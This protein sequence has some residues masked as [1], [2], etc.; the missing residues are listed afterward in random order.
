MTTLL[1]E[2]AAGRI[3]VVQLRLTLADMKGVGQKY[4][5]GRLVGGRA[6]TVRRGCI[7]CLYLLLMNWL[8]KTAVMFLLA[9]F[10]KINVHKGKRKREGCR[11]WGPD[12][13]S[14]ACMK[15]TKMA[16]MGL[17]VNSPIEVGLW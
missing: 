3:R 7:V 10:M 5:C 6:D 11:D 15:L 12:S 13:V 4:R 1:G 14:S 17:L 16:D 9:S 2:L 8:L